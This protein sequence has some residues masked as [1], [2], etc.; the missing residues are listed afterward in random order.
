[1]TRH[2]RNTGIALAA[3]V[4]LCAPR[5]GATAEDSFAERRLTMEKWLETRRLISAERQEWRLGRELLAE[6]A[7]TLKRDIAAW[8]E[9]NAQAEREIADAEREIADLEGRRQDFLQAVAGVLET[10]SRLESE[11]R[12]TLARAPEPLRERVKL[13]SRRLPENPAQSRMSLGERAQNVIG[14]LNEMDKFAREIT[15]ASEVR[16]LADGTSAE[17][18]VLYVGLGQAYYCNLKR[19]IAG[20]GRPGPEGWR[21]EPRD[22]IAEAVAAAVAIYRNERPAAYI[23]LPASLR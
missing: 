12:S 15:V 4:A 5:G 7:E 14:I 23:A 10:V 16:E 1:M 3:L 20:I 18:T 13:L 6:R 2:H 11:L 21:W 9:K 22:D 19:G 8:R 17:V